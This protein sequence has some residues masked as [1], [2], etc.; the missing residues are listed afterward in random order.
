MFGIFAKKRNLILFLSLLK[1]SSHLSSAPPKHIKLSLK[2]ITEKYRK[3]VL[4]N[5]L[6]KYQPGDL[7][8][9][10]FWWHFC[11]LKSNLSK[12][13]WHLEF[14]S[15]SCCILMNQSGEFAYHQRNNFVCQNDW[16]ANI[17]FNFSICKSPKKLLW[18]IIICK[19]LICQND[20]WIWSFYLFLFHWNL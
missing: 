9:A 13:I 10:I 18:K 16:F 4:L 1:A 14:C 2:K 3:N 19:Y 11:I 20:L 8:N 12:T 5:Y 15:A 17:W 7:E 6:Q